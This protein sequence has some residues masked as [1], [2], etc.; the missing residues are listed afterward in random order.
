MVAL[1]PEGLARLGSTPAASRLKLHLVGDNM[2]GK[3]TRSRPRRRLLGG[4]ADYVALALIA[5]AAIALAALALSGVSL[6]S[7]TNPSPTSRPASTTFDLPSETPTP[8]PEG[9]QLMG[10][11]LLSDQNVSTEAS[12]WTLSVAAGLVLNLVDVN[13]IPSPEAGV[14]LLTTDELQDR[15]DAVPVLS[16][17]TVVQS[18]TGDI[19]D[20]ADPVSVSAGVQLLWQSVA[21]K[22]ATPIV[23]LVPPSDE[24]GDEVIELN[25]L[26]RAAATAAGYGV[27]DLYTPLAAPDGSYAPNYSTDGVSPNAAASQ[28]LAD[29]AKA[30]LPPL[31]PLK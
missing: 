25:G 3:S 10:A 15:L 22:G 6:R 9:E 20:G 30:Q 23:A 17:Y 16:G 13:E 8:T 21:G 4:G 14:G 1:Q 31:S 19:E 11:S 27:L 12:W 18:G 2:A 26:L 29:T 7:G 24:Y 28:L 5:V